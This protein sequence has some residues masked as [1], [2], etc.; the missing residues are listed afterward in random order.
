MFV[1]HRLFRPYAPESVRFRPGEKQQAIVRDLGSEP[2]RGSTDSDLFHQRLKSG[3]AAQGVEAGI[4]VEKNDEAI[5]FL[6][7]SLEFGDRP[8][9]IADRR[10][11]NRPDV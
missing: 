4:D 5:P 7:G 2:D 11:L 10:E 3:I 6:V 8:F 1:N 9:V